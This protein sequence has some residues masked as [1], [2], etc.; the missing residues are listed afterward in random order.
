MKHEIR[1]GTY[2]NLN[3]KEMGISMDND[4]NIVFLSN[5]PDD[6][7]N[8]FQLREDYY[9]SFYTIV[10]A[11]ADFKKLVED[12]EI[13]EIYQIRSHAI[14]KKQKVEVN[15]KGK[16]VRISTD[17]GAVAEVCGM[18]MVERAYYTKVVPVSELKIIEEKKV[19]GIDDL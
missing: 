14:Y 18:E 10:I 1:N 6:L 17:R 15:G 12:G 2:I 4:G 3:N 8:G 19:L 5:D 13:K 7:K 16:T 11:F 9:S